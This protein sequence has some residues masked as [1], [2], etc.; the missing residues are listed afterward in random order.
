MREG[1]VRLTVARSGPTF[2]DAEPP[3]DDNARERRIELMILRLP[4]RLQSTVRWLRYPSARWVRI[5]TGLLL[6]IGGLLSILPILGLWMLQLGL[7]LLGED[8]PPLRRGTGHVLAWI[9][10]RR[11]HWMGLHRPSTSHPHVVTKEDP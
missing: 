10:R 1:A 6:I 7:V 3:Y 8:I 4:R 9:E 11:P 5:P 2:A